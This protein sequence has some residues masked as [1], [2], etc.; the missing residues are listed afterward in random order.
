MHCTCVTQVPSSF[1]MRTL[2]HTIRL[3]IVYH[4]QRKNVAKKMLIPSRS[5]PHSMWLYY[6]S[7]FDTFVD[8]KDIQEIYT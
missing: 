4:E 6:F 5:L 1:S 2:A 7:F 3:L 8:S